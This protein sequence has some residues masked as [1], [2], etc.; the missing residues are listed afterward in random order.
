M[1]ASSVSFEA[2]K[3]NRLPVA[4]LKVASFVVEFVREVDGTDGETG[5]RVAEF[6]SKLPFWKRFIA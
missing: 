4:R 3:L 1:L 6:L 5:A 2:K